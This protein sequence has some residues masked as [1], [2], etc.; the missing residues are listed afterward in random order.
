[1]V[2]AVAVL[3][4]VLVSTTHS[5]ETVFPVRQVRRDHTAT[6]MATGVGMHRTLQVNGASMTVLTPVTKTMAHLPLAFLGRPPKDALVICFGM[7]TTFRSLLSWDIEAVAVELVPSVPDL[8]WYYHADALDVVRSPKGRI[9]ID[10]GR[11][12]LERSPRRYD[13]I[14]IDPPYP[15]E[16][17]GSS[18]LYT[19]EFYAIARARLRDGGILQQWIPRTDVATIA[20]VARA[21][22]ESFPHVRAFPVVTR[23]PAVDVLGI[24]FLA[25]ERP[26]PRFSPADLA[27]KVP[28]RAKLDALEWYPTAT[29]EMV[30]G[31][32]TETERTVDEVIALARWAPTLEDDRPFNEY[33][34]LRRLLLQ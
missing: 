12:L 23:Q 24:H 4:A 3:A 27:L 31:I 32:L 9:V 21:L 17:A 5:Y 28:P 7:G 25:S 33:Y 10:D 22:A 15:A 20:S 6:V 34:L 29:L 2:P 16:A 1:V 18:L 14:T 13:V 19:R 11:R 30:F 8:F 26:M